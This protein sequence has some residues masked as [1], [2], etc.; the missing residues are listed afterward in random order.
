MCTQPYYTKAGR[1]LLAMFPP[2]GPTR[3]TA[4]SLYRRQELR[5]VKLSN[6]TAEPQPTRHSTTHTSAMSYRFGIRIHRHR[7]G[8][9][10]GN[11]PDRYERRHQYAY[12]NPTAVA[13]SLHFHSTPTLLQYYGFP[14]ERSWSARWPTTDAPSN[15]STATTRIW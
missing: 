10:I 4:G 8:A 13:H 14:Q 2:R 12:I 9:S 15:W 3:T 1:D 11:S 7:H 6:K 5:P